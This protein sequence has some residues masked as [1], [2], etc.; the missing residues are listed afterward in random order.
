MSP[1]TSAVLA[2]GQVNVSRI[3]RGSHAHALDSSRG[4]NTGSV[5][6]ATSSAISLT[7]RSSRVMLSTAA[8]ASSVQHTTP[9][10]YWRSR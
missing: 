7:A 3:P 1:S 10:W 8:G 4:M 6:L 5:E 2:A 9:T